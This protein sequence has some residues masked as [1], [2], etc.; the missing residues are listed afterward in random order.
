MNGI[1]IY[2]PKVLFRYEVE[3]RI[4]IYTIKK[5]FM[6]K[7]LLP[8]LLITLCLNVFSQK[9]KDPSAKESLFRWGIKG[10]LNLNKI[11]GQSFK[12]EFKYNYSLGGFMQINLT[13][14]FGIQPELNFVQTSAEQSDDI[15][16]IYDDLFLDGEQK[17]AKLGYLKL[18]GLLNID[19][20]P[21]QRVKLQLGPQWGM[22]VSEAV[23]SVKTARDIFKKGELSVVGGLMLQL[24]LIHIG[25]R[26]EIGLTNINGIDEKDKWKSQTWNFFVGITL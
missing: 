24:P 4:V 25:T 20:G 16:V 7:L 3:A 6:K 1:S 15:T 22:L 5:C 17:K 13:R 8:L 23:D 18:A 9:R 19:V 21:S 10:G 2:I 14:K 26:Y 11:D 12:D